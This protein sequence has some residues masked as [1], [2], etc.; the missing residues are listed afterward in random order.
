MCLFAPGPQFTFSRQSWDSGE[1]GRCSVSDGLTLAGPQTPL[2]A[3][4]SPPVLH[5]SP[6]QGSACHQAPAPQTKGGCLSRTPRPQSWHLLSNTG[7]GSHPEVWEPAWPTSPCESR[8]A[9]EVRR[10]GQEPQGGCAQGL[11][12]GWPPL[13]PGSATW[14]PSLALPLQD[15]WSDRKGQVHLDSQQ[16]YQLLRAQRAPEGLYLLFKRPFGTCDPNDYLIE[17]GGSP[18]AVGGV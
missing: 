13:L 11:C 16:D 12:C 9:F 14:A 15:A 5:I 7:S 4:L 10:Q 18:L 8:L 6:L 17:V 1:G 3:S 2:P